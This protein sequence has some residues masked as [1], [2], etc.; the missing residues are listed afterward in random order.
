MRSN[1]GGKRNLENKRMWCYS[2]DF[3][4]SFNEK[5][6]K[7]ASGPEMSPFILCDVASSK[8]EKVEWKRYGSGS[9]WRSIM[10]QS[11]TVAAENVSERMSVS[12]NH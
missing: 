2:I 1:L 10:L 7:I 12:L 3:K 8:I 4:H 5:L 11:A 6:L 9:R